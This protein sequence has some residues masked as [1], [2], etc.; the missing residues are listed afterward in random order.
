MTQVSTQAELQAAIA[1][2]EAD[3]EVTADFQIDAG[4]RITY[5]A[6][7]SSGA[8]GP[9]TMTKAD[10]HEGTLFLIENRGSLT[11]SNI[12]LD[13]AKETHSGTS[14]TGSLIW[15]PTGTLILDTGA[16][17][18]NNRTVQGGGISCNGE[19]SPINII[20]RGNA[21]IRDNVAYTGGGIYVF[22]TG[23]S[24]LQ[25]S[26]QARIENNECTGY[27]G[28][29]CHNGRPQNTLLMSGEAVIAN[30]RARNGGGIYVYDSGCTISGSTELS[31]NQATEKGGGIYF[32][33]TGLQIDDGVNIQNNQAADQG[34]GL[35]LSPRTSAGVAIHGQVANNSAGSGGGVGL[36]APAFGLSVD[37]SRAKLNGNQTLGGGTGS[38]GGLSVSGDSSSAETLSILMDDA[39]FR[40]NRAD[41][42]G[43]G[44][45]IDYSGA[46]PF[47]V[48]ATNCR[49]EG[50]TAGGNGGGAYLRGPASGGTVRFTNSSFAA[51]R[52][53]MG[54][55]GGLYSSEGTGRIAIQGGSRITLNSA[56]SGGGI[57]HSGQRVL[58]L[59]NAHFDGNTASAGLGIYN[60]GSLTFE[61]GGELGLAVAD[62]PD[63]LYLQDEDAVPMLY[64][65]LALGSVIQLERSDYVTPNQTGTPIVLAVSNPV[66]RGEDALAFRAPTSGGE[67]WGI[68]ISDDRH[69]VLWEPV[70][71][72]IRY[73]NTM[74]A[75]NP[76]PDSYTIVT[77]TITL[78]PPAGIPGYYFLGWFDAPEGGTQVT[79]I[80]L[81]STGDRTL[82]ARWYQVGF[83]VF[84][85]GNDEGGPPAENVPP[86]Q[87]VPVG[88]GVP[89][90]EE[91]PTR[92]GYVFTGWNTDPS[93]GGTA[94]QPGDS[95][96]VTGD[97]TLYAQWEAVPPTIHLITYE[98]N[99]QSVEGLP[100]QQEV[101]EG[102][103][104][105][106]SA[107]IPTRTGYRFLSWN[108]R[109][110][111]SGTAYQPGQTV[112]PLYAD[113]TLYA[114]WER[115]EHTLTYHGNDAGGPAAHNIP[116]PQPIY[117]DQAVP[118][119]DMIPTR[120]GYL[121]AGWNTRPD[122]SGAAYQPGDPFGPAVVD[123]DLYAQ[124][125]AIPPTLHLLTY[126]PND[127]GGPS[128]ENIPEQE[129]IEEG[130]TADLSTAI[131]T[132]TGYQFLGWNTQP[133][134]SGT[135]FRPGQTVGPFYSDLTVYAQ[136]E[137][138]EHTLTY[139]GNDAGGPAAHNIPAPQP[140]YEVQAV[141]LSN[142][143]PTRDGYRFNGW[144]TRPDGSGTAYQPGDSFGPATADADLYAQWVRI[145]H[146][147]TYHANDAGGPEAQ[148]IPDPQTIYEDQ[149][150]PLSDII[151][152][153]E[154]Y[155]FTGWNT[156]PD[157]SGTAYQPGASFGPATAD[158]DL[159]AQWEAVPPTLYLLTYEPNDA[160]G[161]PAEGIPAQR[162]IREGETAVLSTA[163]PTRT[164]YRFLGWNTAPDGTGTAY[165]PGQ[166]VGPFYANLTI[167]AQWQRVEHTLTYH[168]NDE[169]GP[170]A[171]WIPAPQT[172]Y[173][174]RSVPLSDA[175]PTREGYLFTGWNTAADGSGA[176]Y[177]PGAPFGP[178]FADAD[179]YAQWA[180]LPP[181]RYLLTYEG[182][183]ASGPPA[184]DI[185]GQQEVREGDTVELSS[186]IPTR[187]GYR[188]TGWNTEP[189]GSG[190]AYQ[191][192]QTVGP[193]YA[194]L[195]IFAQWQR[196]EHTLTYHG[197]DAGGP[198]AQ[199]IPFPQ[200]V[201]ERQVISLP[202]VIPT[203]EGYLF[204]GWNTAADGSGTAYQPG[205]PFGPIY[206]D[207]DL[208]AQWAALPPLM[209]TLAYYGN[210]AGGP[211]AQNIPGPVLVPD[212]QSVT[213]SGTI[214]T[215]EG[216]AFFGWNTD[217]SGNGTAY[218]PGDTI[219]NVR[220]D[221]DL[222]A[223]W[224]PLPPPICC[225][226]TYCGNDAGGPPACCIPCP[227]RILAGQ[228]ARISCCSPCRACYCFTG[229]NTDPCGKGQTFCPGQTI[230]PVTGDVCL[231]AQWRRLPPPKSCYICR[232]EP[233]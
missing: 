26:D 196:V 173:E 137:Q 94:Y 68:R 112:G 16:V 206:S 79:E 25:I 228:C 41:I 218:R 61:P 22:F 193:F 150:V 197:N 135:A 130:N 127:V 106:L 1:A 20:M 54:A 35:Y 123:T 149:A 205:D 194:D 203:R 56:E 143:V 50:N 52:A 15:V 59:F 186:V 23:E 115:L 13:G 101:P 81:G 180:A 224:I 69:E 47:T 189:D 42:D 58:A 229:W 27:G 226:L 165:Q 55:G 71:Y 29:I 30:N 48:S 33:G 63:G 40:S 114:Q 85:S 164:G 34:G 140:I 176:A 211:P 67:G 163:I 200:Q 113:L 108:S 210:D 70:Q 202:D 144:N 107:A 172:I 78:L 104:V 24:S 167:Y 21:A 3:I 183:D 80:P 199:W 215:R 158:A 17:L 170:P 207:A 88:E 184:Q 231:Y 181:V 122:G 227:E 109:P 4:Q 152:V 129:E 175:V 124:W 87:W 51:N 28:G 37:L 133:D 225:T 126:E 45:H 118:L 220:A 99:G 75:E 89:L 57:F 188:F 155:L 142:L 43:A 82:Y 125:E 72:A 145:E 131:P 121:F 134:G 66:L 39:V 233:D 14:T 86:P 95:I 44:V 187:T 84:Y 31:D 2:Q 6:K 117:E 93:G 178:A 128:A 9:Y 46:M 119:S 171:Q 191:P 169:G 102:E 192:G 74:G 141:P 96:Y 98:P 73:E 201:P 217:S 190:T 139:H 36:S 76:N 151:P 214:P 18:Q 174:D 160:G 198:P 177:Q 7:I 90:S 100:G 154:G 65:N 83:T 159:Y 12:I 5:A 97:L 103:T 230:G 223:Q 168:G 136:W 219:Q 216:F 49:I 222:Y 132:R 111:G 138:V 32:V 62:I 77:P 146:I 38:G 162:E 213:L 147:L 53:V 110:D 64:G 208:Y 182:N 120:E 212:G 91:R 8:G 60:A 116:A 10:G 179:L 204:A 185:P 156:R 105:S 161:P 166:T 221:I 232:R 148:N 19:T 195:T 209:H 11:L 157:G 92:E 153:R